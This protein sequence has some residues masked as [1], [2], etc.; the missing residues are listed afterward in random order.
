MEGSA[1][2]SVGRDSAEMRFTAVE[3]P[4]IALLTSHGAA[5]F[6]DTFECFV[7]SSVSTNFEEIHL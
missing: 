4:G 3:S 7:S 5:S 6:Y 2:A 1:S